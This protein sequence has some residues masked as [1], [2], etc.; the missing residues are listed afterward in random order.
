MNGKAEERAD[1]DWPVSEDL[2]VSVS[3]LMQIVCNV[4]LSTKIPWL[5]ELAAPN[6]PAYL[7]F[8]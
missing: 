7:R 6:P 5:G 8:L 4:E 3:I 2:A 1:V